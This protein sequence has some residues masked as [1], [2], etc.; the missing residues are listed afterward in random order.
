MLSVLFCTQPSNRGLWLIE[1]ARRN[2]QVLRLVCKDWRDSSG[3][4]LALA[5]KSSVPFFG[6]TAAASGPLITH[7]ASH[8][9]SHSLQDVKPSWRHLPT[10]FPHV[11]SV[12]LRH[13]ITQWDVYNICQMPKL[14]IGDYAYPGG[15][16]LPFHSMTNLTSLSFPPA[17]PPVDFEKLSL[18]TKLCYLHVFD[19]FDGDCP[20]PYAALGQL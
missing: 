15:Q 17:K 1:I 12:S 6:D 8:L 14:H 7:L 13:C 20:L 18:L 9:D 16:Q 5:G 19:R 10:S 4:S 3:R 11:Q 2:K